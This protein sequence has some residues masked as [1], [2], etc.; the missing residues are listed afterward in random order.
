MSRFALPPRLAPVCFDA[1]ALDRF[2]ALAP[3]DGLEA[4]YPLHAP[5]QTARFRADAE[6]HDLLASACS[7]SHGKPKRMPIKYPARLCLRLLE[8]LGLSPQQTQ[9]VLAQQYAYLIAQEHP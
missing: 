3:V 8:R 9:A 5:E 1:A 6:A 4:F 7:D 2:R